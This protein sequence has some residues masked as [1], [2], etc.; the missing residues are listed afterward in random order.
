MSGFGELQDSLAVIGGSQNSALYRPEAQS[1]QR[2]RSRLYNLVADGVITSNW[3]AEIQGLRFEDHLETAPTVSDLA[4]TQWVNISGGNVRYDAY[5]NFQSSDRNRN[6]LT[7]STTY[8][9]EGAGG[10]TVKVGGDADKTLFPSVNFTTGTPTDP[11]FC[12]TGLTCG[13]QILFRGF[14]SAG[15]RQLVDAAGSVAQQTVVERKG[16]TDRTGKSYTLYLRTSGGSS[17]G[18]P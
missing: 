18:S 10:H 8:F 16:I 11:S 17:P 7:L 14:H 1:T 13:A 2:Q 12:P 5:S 6:A 4:T 15:Q 9:F 3:S